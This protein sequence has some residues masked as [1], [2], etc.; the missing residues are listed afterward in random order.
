M[1]LFQF[2]SPFVY[3]VFRDRDNNFKKKQKP[4]AA[5]LETPTQTLAQP[6]M[7]RPRVKEKTRKEAGHVPKGDESDESDESE[8]TSTKVSSNA[9]FLG[10]GSDHS[11][12][13]ATSAQA[14]NAQATS[15]TFS[16]ACAT[17][18]KSSQAC[19]P[20]SGSVASPTVSVKSPDFVG[21]MVSVLLARSKHETR[22]LIDTEMSLI[23]EERK[24]VHATQVVEKKAEL[25][26][27]E[28]RAV[29]DAVRAVRGRFIYFLDKFF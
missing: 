12:A 21:E 13:C 7:L 28:R 25:E 16:Q 17:S 1:T 14:P 11:Q 19:A 10:L 29:D 15:A 22:E 24:R 23:F 5:L 20:G 27:L 8:I 18:A 3:I 2:Q 6:K 9:G 4:M 26:E